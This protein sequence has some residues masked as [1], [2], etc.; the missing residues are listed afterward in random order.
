MYE[1][2]KIILLKRLPDSFRVIDSSNDITDLFSFHFFKPNISLYNF[3]Y[4]CTVKI[5]LCLNYII[6]K[7]RKKREEKVKLTTISSTLIKCRSCVF[8]S[9]IFSL[10]WIAQIFLIWLR[11]MNIWV[12]RKKYEY[13]SRLLSSFRK[14]GFRYIAILTTH[15]YTL[16]SKAHKWSSR[17][18]LFSPDR[19]VFEGA[20]SH[21]FIRMACSDLL[22]IVLK[23]LC[24]K[25]HTYDW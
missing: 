23:H 17:K 14:A 5:L 12:G 10:S 24:L 8:L 18:L 16:P 19:H 21:G 11:V 22:M 13:F 9:V 25:Y 7:G 20:E 4:L 1:K 3:Q 15:I 6:I 2:P